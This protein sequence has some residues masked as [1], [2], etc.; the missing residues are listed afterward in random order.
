MM[1][2]PVSQPW[3]TDR[4][5]DALVRVVESG[6]ITQATCVKYFEQGLQTLFLQDVAVCSSGTAALHLALRALHIG[7]GD[8]VLVPNL[9][10]IATINAVTYVGATPVLVDVDRRTWNMAAFFE[11]VTKRTKAV[12]FVHL[13]GVEID[14]AIFDA[15]R[16][17]KL[18]II[19]DAA[20]AFG[21]MSTPAKYLGTLVDVGTFSFYGNKV[22]TTGE[23][24]AVTSPYADVMALVRKLRGQ[25]QGAKRYRHDIVGY[26]YR[27]TDM[28]AAL[29]SAQLAR[30]RE[31][32]MARTVV[33]DVYDEL[34]PREFE[35]QRVPSSRCIP[36]L[37]TVLCPDT[38]DRIVLQQSLS[39]R[40]IETRC[41]FPP[42]HTQPAYA[43]LK[44][45]FPHSM[46]I[47][48]RGISLP[49]Y[50]ELSI[51]DVQTICGVIKEECYARG[52]AGAGAR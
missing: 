44:G 18:Y 9:T 30:L 28:Q 5:R 7:P 24:G 16:T 4:E 8:E 17:L 19:E 45:Y 2:Y 11:K 26:N 35:R 40:G 22:I 51:F 52:K 37:Y 46:E 13:Y 29:G 34:L 25:G 36:W 39:E 31:I 21:I 1:Y 49:T 15:A 47:H 38:I 43:H 3:L 32:L 50:P 12:I 14:H 27:M 10:Y 6:Q 42:L 20:Q 48:R 41:I 23:G 33:R